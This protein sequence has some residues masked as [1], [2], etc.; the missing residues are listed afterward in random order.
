MKSCALCSKVPYLPEYGKFLVL[1]KYFYVVCIFNAEII[2][3]KL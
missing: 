1:N 2:F 3:L